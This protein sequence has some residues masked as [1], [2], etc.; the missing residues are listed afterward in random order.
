MLRYSLKYLLAFSLPILVLVAFMQYR[1]MT[2]LPLIE[3]FVLIPLVE[4]FVKPDKRN[5]SEE[6]ERI[7]N[8]SLIFDFWIYLASFLQ[9]ALLIV[10]C[11]SINETGLTVVDYIGR[12][13][14]MGL[15]C[16]IY[17]INVAH[18][19]GHRPQ[20]YNHWLAKMLLLTSMYMHFFI[21]H[22]RGHHKNVSTLQD[23]ATSRKGESVY[24]FWIRSIIGSFLS[25][26]KIENKRL[27][28]KG[29][30]QFSLQNEMIGYMILQLMLLVVIYVFFGGLALLS[31]L[32]AAFIGIL[33]LETVNYIEHYG[34]LRHQK[35]SGRYERVMPS[36]SWNSNHLLGRMLLFELS[37][38]SDHHYL[39][40]RK[41]QILRHMDDSPQMP[42]GYPGM[43]LLSLLP[44]IW[45]YVM[46]KRLKHENANDFHSDV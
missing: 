4:L 2:F 26:W 34:L 36:H 43:I 37:R 35:A 19:L 17:G 39:A 16:G 31:F 28:K 8:G 23:P 33:L 29:S 25:A 12:I 45:F 6:E 10:F 14:A 5:H 18:E 42:T 22:N 3:A 15:M 21:E 44:P 30:R 38:H 11:Y 41:Y 24:R 7:L 32:A 13:I 9:V 40:S 27:Q 20:K 46:D 1:L